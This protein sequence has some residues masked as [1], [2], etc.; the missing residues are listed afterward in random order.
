VRIVTRWQDDEALGSHLDHHVRH[1]AEN[2][3]DFR[4][5]LAENSRRLRL[6]AAEPDVLP[7]GVP[8]PA[9][10][11]LGVVRDQS[12]AAVS[13]IDGDCVIGRVVEVRL[14]AVQQS[15]PASS[16]TRR[17][18]TATSLSRRNRKAARPQPAAGWPSRTML[19]LLADGL[20][21]VCRLLLWALLR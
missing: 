4:E 18:V 13:G 10:R 9:A 19:R 11:E 7:D 21:P 5:V 17:T 16:R 2:T 12:C 14:A 1:P 6:G 20:I 3:H 8:S 15:R